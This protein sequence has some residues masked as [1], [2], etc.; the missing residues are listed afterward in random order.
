[1]YSIFRMLNVNKWTRV[2]CVNY[3]MSRKT[4]CR[5]Y[6]HLKIILKCC[7]LFTVVPQF[8]FF[9]RSS[10]CS[11][12]TI[13]TCLPCLFFCHSSM[14]KDTV[15]FMKWISSLNVLFRAKSATYWRKRMTFS[16]MHIIMIMAQILWNSM[17][18]T[19]KFIAMELISN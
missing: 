17:H 10:E 11:A 8:V 6:C 14:H 15:T 4:H 7:I 12:H 13:H 19:I 16:V 3:D 5:F 9:R 1:M 2:R 18:Y